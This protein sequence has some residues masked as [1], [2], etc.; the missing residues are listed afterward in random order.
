M[1]DR[2]SGNYPRVYR[3]SGG[4]RIGLTL[5]GVLLSAD[6][7]AGA[8]RFVKDSARTAQSPWWPAS[9][10]VAL[11]LFCIY[12]LL[13]TFRSRVVLY[14]DR[15]ERVGAMNTAVLS[16]DEIRGWRILPT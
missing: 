12:C 1:S 14:P 16:R 6:G 10:F 4:W 5:C 3:V 11:A 7:I 13:S 2:L 9:L 15:M 8:C